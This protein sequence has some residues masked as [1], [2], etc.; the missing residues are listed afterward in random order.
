MGSLA[1]QVDGADGATR[2][3]TKVTLFAHEPGV[4]IAQTSLN[5]DD[6]HESVALKAILSIELGG[7]LMQGDAL[8]A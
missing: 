1:N 2:F 5:T 4:A 3:V 6:T 7:V 8:R